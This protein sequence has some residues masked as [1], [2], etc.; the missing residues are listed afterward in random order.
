MGFFRKKETETDPGKEISWLIAGL[1]NPGRDYDRTWHNLGFLCVEL[2]QERH[3]FRCDR[4]RF[5]GLTA[6]TR[7]FGEKQLFLMPQTFMNE[8]GQSVREAAAFYKIPPERILV[9]YD[10]F[11]LPLGSLRIRYKGSAGSH[12][13]MKSIIYHL[14]TEDFPRLRMGF[15]PKP[16]HKDVIRFVTERIPQNKQEVCFEMLNRAAD[17]VEL[18]LQKDLEAAMSQ[19]N[20]NKHESV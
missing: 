2:L 12:N 11:A 3:Q 10:D 13:G 20:G 15:G 16:E 9:L 6:Q 17:A 7:L 4:I 8:S 14:G 19:M 5:K 1:G 18:I